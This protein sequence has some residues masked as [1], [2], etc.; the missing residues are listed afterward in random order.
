MLVI[1]DD[2]RKFN[3]LLLSWKFKQPFLYYGLF[4]FIL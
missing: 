1:I 3:I 4:K 2:K